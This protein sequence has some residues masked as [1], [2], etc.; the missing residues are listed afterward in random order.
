MK[1]MLLV[2]VL[3]AGLVGVAG[4]AHAD[5]PP[6][7]TGSFTLPGTATAGTNGYCPFE[8]RFDYVSHQRV[9]QSTNPDGSTEIRATG[10]ARATV[11]NVSTGK[12]LRYNV[13]G[14]GTTTVHPNGAFESDYTGPNLFFTTVANSHPGVPQLAFTTGH[15]R[16]SVAASGLTTSYRLNGHS[17]DVCAALA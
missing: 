11:T 12:S 9:S 16:F 5:R 1:K 14:P 8:V 10:N 3:S 6:T 15:V 2:G 7:D 17:T 13:N 4:P